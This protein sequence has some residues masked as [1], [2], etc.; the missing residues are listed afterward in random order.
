MRELYVETEKL[1]PR[2]Q[3]LSARLGERV[4]LQEGLLLF[5]GEQFLTSFKEPDQAIRYYDMAA[6]AYPESWA[7]WSGLGLAYVAKGDKLQAARMYEKSLQLN[8]Q[9]EDAKK[10]LSTLRSE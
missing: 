3:A 10:A 7:A 2:Y 1:K 4:A 9:N 8:P 6:E 5:F